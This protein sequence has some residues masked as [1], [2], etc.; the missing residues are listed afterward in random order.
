MSWSGLHLTPVF[1]VAQ[2]GGLCVGSH[3]H[4]SGDITNTVLQQ[5]QLILGHD[6]PAAP[7]LI[8]GVASLGMAAVDVRIPTLMMAVK[9]RIPTFMMA[10]KVRIPTFMMAVKVRIPTFMMAVNVRISTFMMAVKVRI[11]TFMMA[12]KVRIIAFMM[13]VKVWIPTFMMAVKDRIPTVMMAVNVSQ[14]HIN[15]LVHSYL[16]WLCYFS[17]WAMPKVIDMPLSKMDSLELQR[18]TGK[19]RI[20]GVVTNAETV[21][22]CACSCKVATTCDRSVN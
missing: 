9:V 19:S 21:S 6:F 10:V 14:L 1:S 16:W 8:H 18:L 20:R 3:I 7:L 17:N 12:A 15:G 22:G 4:C 5:D 2:K 11:P 13:A